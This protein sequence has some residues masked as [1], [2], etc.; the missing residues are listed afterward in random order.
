MD[1]LL[2]EEAPCGF[3]RLA[4]D[5][6][7]LLT[8]LT[9]RTLCGYDQET[10]EQQHIDVLLTPGARIFNQTHVFPLLRMH[11]HVDEVYMSLRTATGA[12]VPVLLN[13]VR[14]ESEAGGGVSDWVV[15]G[16][17]RRNQFEDELLQAKKA[18]EAADS[19]KGRFLAMMSH[20]LRAP[21]SG[22]SLAA[23]VISSGAYG[24]VTED[25]RSE[26]LRIKEAS[27]YVLRLV[28]DLLNYAQLE[29]GSVEVVR[30]P[31]LLSDVLQHATAMVRHLVEEAG[32]T[33]EADG[34][35]C[36]LWVMADEDRLQQVVLNLL[37][38]AVKFTDRGGRVTLAWEGI[39][40]HVLVHVKDTGCGMS[41][42]R[43]DSIFQ[44]FIQIDRASNI[45]AGGV[46]LGLAI[47]RELA[48]LMGG[49]ITVT[50]QVGKGSAFTIRLEAT[51][52]P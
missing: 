22:I 27:Q 14:R 36:E 7:I 49:D 50:S 47:S 48:R 31:L 41:A 39:T 15:V 3:L 40:D 10:L 29:S 33:L 38:N 5:G 11:G 9:L 1:D 19:A 46:G 37:V 17:R 8:N 20:D 25:Q 24:S 34:A 16:M 21:L 18:A 23:G 42:E 28:K 32:L 43:L 12:D 35:P 4:D 45:E 44:P 2:L 51:E 6:T 26:L 30:T 52:A 13:A